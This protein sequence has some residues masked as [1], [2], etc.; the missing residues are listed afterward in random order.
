VPQREAYRSWQPAEPS[1]I[2]K[3]LLDDARSG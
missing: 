2:V 3:K 1:P